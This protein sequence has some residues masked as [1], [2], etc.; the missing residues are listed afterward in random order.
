MPPSRFWMYSAAW[1]RMI[2]IPAESEYEPTDWPPQPSRIAFARCFASSGY[3]D[4][5][6]FVG[7]IT[8]ANTYCGGEKMH[9]KLEFN[10]NLTCHKIYLCHLNVIRCI[11]MCTDIVHLHNK[12]KIG[13]YLLLIV[14][15]KPFIHRAITWFVAHWW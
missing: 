12:S 3:L 1:C 13:E 9:P 4:S 7:S 11:W 14:V 5:L 8:N 6:K 15:F 10:L 2:S